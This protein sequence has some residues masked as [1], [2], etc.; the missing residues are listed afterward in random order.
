MHFN[1][2]KFQARAKKCHEKLGSKILLAFFIIALPGQKVYLE[3]YYSKPMVVTEK[4]KKN[5]FSDREKRLGRFLVND[6]NKS[7]RVRVKFTEKQYK[8]I[9]HKYINESPR[10]AF[11]Q[12][13]LFMLRQAQ[14]ARA[15]QQEL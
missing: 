3:K 12:L 5:Q 15:P 13:R 7:F 11:N 4:I 1:M 14:V 8:A 10:E 2:K 9:G 6:F